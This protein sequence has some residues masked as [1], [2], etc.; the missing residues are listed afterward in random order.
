MILEKIFSDPRRTSATINGQVEISGK[1]E[2]FANRPAEAGQAV[3]TTKNLFFWSLGGLCD[4]NEAHASLVRLFL[5]KLW[6][7]EVEVFLAEFPEMS[8]WSICRF[9]PSATINLGGLGKLCFR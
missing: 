9:G 8:F 7:C 3:E 1:L 2:N 4:Q 5:K 6:A